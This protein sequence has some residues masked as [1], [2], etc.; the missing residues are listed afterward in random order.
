MKQSFIVIGQGLTDLFEFK[1][2]IEY[3]HERISDILML[4]TPLSK[5][6]LS[7]ACIIMKPTEENHFQA[8]YT[9]LE[10]I[11]YP[12]PDT[13]KKFDLINEWANEYN[14]K[15]RGLDVKSRSEFAEDDLYFTYLKGVLRLERFIPPLQ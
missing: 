1:T 2:L 4:H 9:I 7:S 3:N 5:D 14:F 12:Y 6:K 8:I 11:K 10:G 13:N 15:V